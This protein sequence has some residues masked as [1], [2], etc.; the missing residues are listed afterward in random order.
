MNESQPLVNCIPGRN[1]SLLKYSQSALCTPKHSLHCYVFFLPFFIIFR[2]HKHIKAHNF[3]QESQLFNTP[4]KIHKCHHITHIRRHSQFA[5]LNHCH[6][7][8]RDKKNESLKHIIHTIHLL[9]LPCVHISVT[10][11]EDT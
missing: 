5:S 11:K 2:A 6:A 3:Q 7:S 1:N 4:S 10:K 8:I 9:G